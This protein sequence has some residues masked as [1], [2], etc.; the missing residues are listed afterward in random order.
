MSL[1]AA[2]ETDAQLRYFVSL[3]KEARGEEDLN[4]QYLRHWQLMETIAESRNYNKA[5][6]LRDLSGA[7]ILTPG[8]KPRKMRLATSKVYRVLQ[9]PDV[10]S[11]PGYPPG[12][13][14]CRYT[15]MDFVERG[16][17]MRNATAHF[18]GFRRGEPTQIAQ[19][20]CYAQCENVH[21]QLRRRGRLGR[22]AVAV[23]HG[24]L[25]WNVLSE[26]KAGLRPN[27]QV[28]YQN[29]LSRRVAII[30]SPP[31]T[32]TTI[33]AIP[34]RRDPKDRPARPRAT[35]QARGS[36]NVPSNC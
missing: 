11:V 10:Q 26:R 25:S 24:S 6:D 22:R 29:A 12:H 35:N 30:A 27:S 9:V 16:Y 13:P 36:R 4:Y 21:V 17:A 19:L 31:S 3:Y 33:A 14:G 7:V 15:L 5:D 28:E 20:D 23:G 34:P 8:G 18:G 32:R 2:L 1:S